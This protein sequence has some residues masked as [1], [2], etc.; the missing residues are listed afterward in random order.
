M[1]SEP[2]D[3]LL[4]CKAYSID[5]IVEVREL[6]EVHLA[7]LAAQHATEEDIGAL[8]D[9]ISK[10]YNPKLSPREY[11]EIDVAFHA[12]LAEATGN[13]LFAVLSQSINTV[14]LDPIQSEYEHNPSAREDS[15]R[16]HS[17]I[18]NA[19]KVHDPEA[20]RKAMVQALS[21]APKN[22]RLYSSRGNNKTA[23]GSFAQ[24]AG[25]RAHTT[26]QPAS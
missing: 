13:S 12:H 20:A 8:E 2:I 6:F 24:G 26:Q 11:A 3:L 25:G 9:S 16:E 18:L 21:N 17:G 14:M 1:V 15:I 23:D 19:V 10:L 5:E 22:W 4:R 7:G